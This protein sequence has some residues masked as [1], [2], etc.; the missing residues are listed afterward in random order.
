MAALTWLH[1]SDWRQK[2][3]EFNQDVVRD[4][5]LEDIQERVKRIS[6]QVEQV[7]FIVFSGDVKE[8]G[9]RQGLLR[10]QKNWPVPENNVQLLYYPVFLPHV[11]Y[12]KLKVKSNPS[13]IRT[14]MPRNW[15]ERINS[16]GAIV[17]TLNTSFFMPSAP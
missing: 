7:D 10:W 9:A 17:L 16:P 14:Y 5:L 6:P 13:A 4:R 11:F 12:Q 3:K 1:L 15:G 8:S 2:G